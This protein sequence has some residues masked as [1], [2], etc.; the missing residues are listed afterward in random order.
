MSTIK[1]NVA[2]NIAQLRK[3]REWTQAELAEMLCYSDKTI[4]KWE[5][6]DSTPD[7][8]MLYQLSELFEVPIEYFF[9]EHDA[10]TD[11]VITKNKSILL[12]NIAKILLWIIVAWL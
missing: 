3:S 9:S 4:S 1:E 5:R 8:E 11:E 12:R 10:P 6:G 2:N 7:V